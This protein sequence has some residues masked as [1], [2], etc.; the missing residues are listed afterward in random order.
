MSETVNNTTTKKPLQKIFNSQWITG[1]MNFFLFLCLLGVLYIANGHVADR[2]LR[3]SSRTQMQIKELEYEYKT[4]KSEVMKKSEETQV[5][6]AAEPLGLK[7]SKEVP[8][9]LQIENKK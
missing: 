4:V 9:K 2:I 3:N 8:I 5:L 7:I 6:K 1:N